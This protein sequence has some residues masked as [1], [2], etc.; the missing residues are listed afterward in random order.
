MSAE[1]ENDDR[2]MERAAAGDTDAFDRIVQ[3]HQHRLQRFA[4]RMLGGDQARGAD[5]AVGALLRLW[6]SRHSYRPC[7]KLGAWLLKAANRLCLDTLAHAQTVI[8]LDDAAEAISDA[9]CQ[10]CVEK[11]VLAHAVRY[12]VMDL[13]EAHRS[14][15]ILSVYEEMSYDEIAEALE[16]SPG[17]VASRKSHAVAMLRRRLA[18]WET[19]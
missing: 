15:L 8:A 1:N 17:T 12:A 19:K 10:S 3:R 11:T 6:E 16:I 13:P 4:T 7:G 2:L 9:T 14:V 18:A 5:V